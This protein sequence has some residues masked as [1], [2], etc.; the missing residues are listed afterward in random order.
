[1]P[2]KISVIAN[3]AAGKTSATQ[4]LSQLSANVLLVPEPVEKW[5]ESGLLDKFYKNKKKHALEMQW[6]AVKTRYN[7]VRNV[8]SVAKPQEIVLIDGHMLTDR[9]VFVRALFEEGNMT[10]DDKETYEK[11][12]DNEIQREPE[13]DEFFLY[14][15]CSPEECLNRSKI[16]ARSEESGLEL[17]YLERLHKN[18]ED[19]V[20]RP[21][22]KKKTIIVDVNCKNVGETLLTLQNTVNQLILKGDVS[23]PIPNWKLDKHGFVS[24]SYP[25]IQGVAYA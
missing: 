6:N 9:H 20:E 4:L 24:V 3:I 1:M 15:R 25:P 17:D 14:L 18:L 10:V 23:F 11:F 13:K 21:E 12:F 22:I 5:R 7:E 19:F 16:R 2:I 8:L